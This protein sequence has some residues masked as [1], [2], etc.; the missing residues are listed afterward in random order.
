M[1]IAA[2]FNGAAF[3]MYIYQYGVAGHDAATAKPFKAGGNTAAVLR[4]SHRE[5]AV[6]PDKKHRNKMPQR[7]KAIVI[8]LYTFRSAKKKTISFPKAVS[9]VLKECTTNP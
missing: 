5:C 2:P 6:S 9:S 4:Q 3:F 8:I 1:I 7:A